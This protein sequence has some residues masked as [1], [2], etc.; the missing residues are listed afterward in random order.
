MAR[1]YS[2]HMQDGTIVIARS[3]TIEKLGLSDETNRL[4]KSLKI[5]K[6]ADVEKPR[7]SDNQS[8]QEA[9]LWFRAAINYVENCG[10]KEMLVSPLMADLMKQPW[11]KA[12]FLTPRQCTPIRRVAGEG[13]LRKLIRKVHKGIELNRDPLRHI[14]RGL[15]SVYWE[16][17][18][19]EVLEGG[20][21]PLPRDIDGFIDFVLSKSKDNHGKVVRLR[22][23][24]GKDYPEISRLLGISTE[25]AKSLRSAA[26]MKM[27]S[28]FQAMALAVVEPVLEELARSGDL[29]HW[30]RIRR[31]LK[32]KDKNKMLLALAIAEHHNLR[33][34]RGNWL[35]SKYTEHLDKLD[36]RLRAVFSRC[37]GY[38][39]DLAKA[40]QLFREKTGHYLDE[41][42]MKA[43]CID[44]WGR[45]IIVQ[46]QRVTIAQWF[47]FPERLN[48]ILQ[49]YGRPMSI[50]ELRNECSRLKS[51]FTDSWGGGDGVDATYRRALTKIDAYPLDQGARW[52]HRDYL[53]EIDDEE[54]AE[55][56][57]W[58]TELIKRQ[59]H[60]VN[61]KYVLSQLER[62]GKRPSWLTKRLLMQVLR[63]SDIYITPQQTYCANDTEDCLCPG[64]VERVSEYLINR[65]S[66]ASLTKIAASLPKKMAYSKD[67]VAF[68]LKEIPGL[69]RLPRSKNTS[70]SEMTH[71][72][73]FG[74][75]TMRERIL[76]SAFSKLP[77]NGGVVTVTD[78]LARMKKAA[79]SLTIF[80]LRP[81]EHM[82]HALMATDQRFH[83]DEGGL[84]ARRVEGRGGA[85][86]DVVVMDTMA[87]L[88]IASNEEI[89]EELIRRWSYGANDYFR[90][91]RLVLCL[92]RLIAKRAIRKLPVLRNSYTLYSQTKEDLMPLLRTNRRRLIRGCRDRDCLKRA[93]KWGLKLM[94]HYFECEEIE[95]LA[96]IARRLLR[97]MK[98][99]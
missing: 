17:V 83:L 18:L 23:I 59:S 76:R 74:N 53:E 78:L 21:D 84:V 32:I 55:I 82:L 71:I 10:F 64:F 37:D 50:E 68:R 96:A 34:W 46:N 79:P 7:S 36:Y 51:T 39:I 1:D 77:K 9:L 24:Q 52:C 92:K 15:G 81:R 30:K 3:T 75:K 43:L 99:R 8:T 56:G 45:K 4:F 12:L 47:R 88:V 33:L 60:P 27:K 87:S 48:A 80:K 6:V 14:Y 42:S 95:D 98:R 28:K 19:H 58:C 40:S 38:T 41:Q 85:L 49:E 86:L 2:A 25:E 44:F 54:L 89:K 90:K 62:K 5:R 16:R 35:S 66:A 65:Q 91:S 63:N 57:R 70:L 11:S 22:L 26:L 72:R 13:T 29:L 61:I 94:L 31:L 69:L 97:K 93:D 73:C 20:D 67:D